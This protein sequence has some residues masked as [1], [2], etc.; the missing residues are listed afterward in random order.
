MIV[1]ASCKQ[2]NVEN[3][4]DISDIKALSA[5]RA[6]AFADGNS[7]II[8]DAFT[9]TGLLMAPG[10]EATSGR[11]AVRN[12]YQSIF[13]EYKTT[14]ESGYSDVKVSGDFAYG[15]GHAKVSLTPR[16]GGDTVIFSTS[17]YINILERQP[18]GS[19][20]TTHDIWNGNEK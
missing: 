19:W 18:D 6:K 17:K 15:I 1:S 11:E 14:L 7:Q 13:D 3:E 2:E 10:A 20:L 8:A 4:N 9:E 16:N 5:K 12:Y